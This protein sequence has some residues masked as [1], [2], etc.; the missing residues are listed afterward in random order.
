M[1]EIFTFVIACAW[2]VIEN[3]YPGVI[4]N[5]YPIK[6]LGWRTYLRHTKKWA[7]HVFILLLSF[8]SFS[9]FDLIE[10]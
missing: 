8:F 4:E 6:K 7:M 9:P 5:R 3:R 2:S 1:T 10:R